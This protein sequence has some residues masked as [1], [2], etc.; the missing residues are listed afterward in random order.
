MS[1]KLSGRAVQQKQCA[2]GSCSYEQEQI[3][4]LQW[5][6]S[7]TRW[8]GRTTAPRKAWLATAP[9]LENINKV[10]IK[11]PTDVTFIIDVSNVEQ[12]VEERTG[13]DVI[14]G[15][16]FS[17]VQFHCTRHAQNI[18][19]AGS[20]KSLQAFEIEKTESGRRMSIG[21]SRDPGTELLPCRIRLWAMMQAND[22]PGTPRE[23]TL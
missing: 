21:S 19:H 9:C 3:S 2:S 5:M 8:N 6:I 20:P 11:N 16:V 13:K 7:Q 15:F 10:S 12:F 17:V 1:S 4:S 23:E 18:A 22:V 14:E